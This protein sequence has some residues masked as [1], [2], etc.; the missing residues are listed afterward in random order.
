M[1]KSF[2][3]SNNLNDHHLK[4]IGY[5]STYLKTIKE[6]FICFKLRTIIFLND[7]LCHLALLNFLISE[8]ILFKDKQDYEF[9]KKLKKS[10]FRYKELAINPFL[11]GHAK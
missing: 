7:V 6:A 3:V 9:I 4:T 11:R 8:Q 10:N 5:L 2:I 1:L